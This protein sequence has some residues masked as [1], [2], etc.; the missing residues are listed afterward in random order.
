MSL[1]GREMADYMV[2]KVAGK[3]AGARETVREEL[4]RRRKKLEQRLEA[5]PV[6][7]LCVA[8][9]LLFFLVFF[10]AETFEVAEV[11]FGAVFRAVLWAVFE[12]VF[13]VLPEAEGSTGL[14]L[15]LLLLSAPFLLLL[16]VGVTRAVLRLF[17]AQTATDF[18]VRYIRDLVRR[19]G[20]EEAMGIAGITLPTDLRDIPRTRASRLI[21][22]MRSLPATGQGSGEAAEKK[23]RAVA[24]R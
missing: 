10:L 18:Q 6:I 19:P 1:K 16:L 15:F 8:I 24:G 5:V 14:S 20:A 13:W 3:L 4:V 17:P 23:R 12:A 7:E 9:W 11:V 2:V 22:A 21:E